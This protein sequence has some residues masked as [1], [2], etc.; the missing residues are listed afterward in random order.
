MT[1]Q[2][3]DQTT[4]TLSPLEAAAVVSTL[5][6]SLGVA[7]ADI[8]PERADSLVSATG[9][10][11][12]TEALLLLARFHEAQADDSVGARMLAEFAVAFAAH[13]AGLA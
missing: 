6:A 12:T 9:C 10:T 5:H 1:D 2:A 4:D 8:T 3:T 11:S 7:H 13:E